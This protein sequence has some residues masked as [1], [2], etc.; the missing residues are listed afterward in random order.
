M[1]DFCIRNLIYGFSSV[2]NSVVTLNIAYFQI[3]FGVLGF[4]FLLVGGRVGGTLDVHLGK[5]LFEFYSENICIKAFK[6]G[7]QSCNITF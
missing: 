5:H 2:Q 4:S 6:G 3:V 1:F 7:R